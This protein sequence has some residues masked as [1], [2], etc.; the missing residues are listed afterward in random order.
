MWG[1]CCWIGPQGRAVCARFPG[2]HNTRKPMGIDD[3]QAVRTREVNAYVAGNACAASVRNVTSR[4]RFRHDPAPQTGKATR[5]RGSRNRRIRWGRGT[6]GAARGATS[7]PHCT[8]VAGAVPR[9]VRLRET[10]AYGAGIAPAFRR[11]EPDARAAAFGAGS[12]CGLSAWQPGVCSW[13]DPV[14]SAQ[15]IS[16]LL[17][18]RCHEYLR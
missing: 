14:L 18:R 17:V 2:P 9:H 13:R 8:G 11:Q 15:P 7:S 6:R 4:R 1:S 12:R 16:R 3:M 10:I 5:P